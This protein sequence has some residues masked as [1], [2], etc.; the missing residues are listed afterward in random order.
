[1]G[2]IM[3]L[4]KS[5]I[6]NFSKS[7]Q[8]NEEE[9]YFKRKRYKK[10]EIFAEFEKIETINKTINLDITSDE[11]LELHVSDKQTIT[12]DF[13]KEILA[14]I[15]IFDDYVQDFCELNY[16]KS[17]YSAKNY[18]VALAWISIEQDKVTMRYWGECVN[19]EL[20]AIF[21]KNNSEWENKDIYYR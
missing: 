4:M 21:V 8:K 15:P 10:E 11:T 16:K 5:I 9:Q 1:M 3:G 13:I 18:M 12:R 14:E 17:S 7:K 2:D 20:E 6:K 19:I